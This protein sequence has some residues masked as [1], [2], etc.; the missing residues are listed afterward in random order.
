MTASDFPAQHRRHAE[1]M[2]DWWARQGERACK[3]VPEVT[4]AVRYTASL[5]AQRMA[6]H[7]SPGRLVLTAEALKNSRKRAVSQLRL[8]RHGTQPRD[9]EAW[10]KQLV[11]IQAELRVELTK[12]DWGWPADAAPASIITTG[13]AA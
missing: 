10:W 12:Q 8:A 7:S 3:G 11:E 4:S 2:A 13:V 1:I 5:L 6:A 9:R